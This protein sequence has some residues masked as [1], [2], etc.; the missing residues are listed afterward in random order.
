MARVAAWGCGS[1]LLLG[2]VMLAAPG[3]VLASA[4]PFTAVTTG[5]LHL[6]AGSTTYNDATCP[7]LQRCFAVGQA[8]S[9][10]MVTETHDAGAS[11]MTLPV[12]IPLNA[13]AC[14]T[15]LTCY[16]FAAASNSFAE[17][18]NGGATW[19]VRTFVPAAVDSVACPSVEDCVAVGTA[20][21]TTQGDVTIT[22][23]GGTS[24][25]TA[26][27]PGFVSTVRCIDAA[28]CWTVGSGVWFSSDMGST[29][30]A[31]ALPEPVCSPGQTVCD[32]SYSELVDVEFQSPT[33]GYVVGGIQCGGPAGSATECSGALFHT[34]D[35]GATWT[36][37]PGSKQQPFGWQITC[38][39]SPCIYATDI[40]TVSSRLYAG[41]GS[42]WSAVQTLPFVT[43]ALACTPDGTFCVDAGAAGNAAVLYD[44]GA[45]TPGGGSGGGGSGGE[46]ALLNGSQSFVAMSSATPSVL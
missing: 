36:W 20:G 13:I 26:V 46:S 12:S 24:W 7:S 33:A 14:P 45:A 5:A 16:A 43:Y 28:H 10:G 41:S 15:A 8:G 9:G 31:E 11:W 29:W 22:R 21:N 6:P 44:S 40:G 23:D 34:A 2:L 25:T 18:T 1:V 4:Q 17:T 38:R 32:V 35:G 30:T 39:R 37:W 3:P 42:S 19:S 27:A